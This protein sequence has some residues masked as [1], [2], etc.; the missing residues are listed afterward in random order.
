MDDPDGDYRVLYVGDTAQGAIAEAFGQFS[1]WTAP[2]LA[3]PPSA[4]AGTVK[5]LVRYQGDPAVL[6]LDDP[7]ELQDLGLRPSSVV[8]RQRPVTQQ[9]AR[10]IYDRGGHDGISWWSYYE[11]MWASFGLWEYSGLLVADDPVPL[12]LTHPDVL[13][14]AGVIK[15]LFS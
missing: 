7:Y 13:E 6:D 10:A 9:W 4:P 11:P 2:I 1:R 12:S 14:A 5:A 3:V 15:R 8:S